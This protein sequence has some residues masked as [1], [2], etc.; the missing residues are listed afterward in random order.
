MKAPLIF[1]RLGITRGFIVGLISAFLG[2]FITRMIREAMGIDWTPA[3]ATNLQFEPT[4]TR[5][6]PYAIGS[7]TGT[8]G[9]LIGVGA[10]TDWL[11]WAVG[12]PGTD[13]HYHPKAGMPE[14]TRYFGMDTN[15]KVVGIQY[16]FTSL[17]VLG[18]GGFFA[19]GIRT[20]LAQAGPTV[21]EADTY[22]TFIG[23]H[24]MVMIVSVIIGI[25]AMAN[26]LVPL[27]IGAQDMAFPRLNGFAFWINVPAA[28]LLLIAPFV[29]GFDT[30]WTGYPPLSLK[31]PLGMQF[32]TMGV[33]VAGFSSIL[34]SLNLLTTIFLMRAPGMTLFRMPIFVWGI[35][36][37]SLLQLTA[38]QFIGLSFLMVT[39]ERLVG[40]PFFSPEGGGN[41]TLYQHLFWF[42]SHPAV[43]IFVLPGLGVISELLPVFSRKPLFGYVPIA[44]SSMA[45]AVMGYLV[46]AHHM[47][48]SAMDPSL[49]IPFMVTTLLVAVPTGVKFFSWL[50]TLWGG[51]IHF[52]TPMWF[53]LGAFMVFLLGGLTGP[54]SALVPTSVHLHDTHFVVAHFHM[55]IF[56]GYVFAFFGALYYWFPKVTGRM[57]NERLGLLHFGLMFPGFTIFTISLARI[58]ILGMRRRIYDYDPTW[59][60]DMNT[61]ERWNLL[62]T[63]GAY[64]VAIGGILMVG[65][66]LFNAAYGRKAVPNPWRS[67]G[68]EWQISSPP[69]ELN[70]SQ[71][72]E[73][74][75]HPYDYG[76]PGAVYAIVAPEDRAENPTDSGDSAS[77]TPMKPVVVPAPGD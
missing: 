50:G 10:M 26:Y 30:G 72:P 25:G 41:V 14:W 62:A 56:G 11:K 4:S 13:G 33:F 1:L 23:M 20:E 44:M 36:A 38:T 39:V 16:L 3:D 17:I 46:W 27:M 70:F 7:I 29:G 59:G 35:I 48:T 71:L 40:I 54:P 63:I 6:I 76:K 45:I 18:I 53:V 15:H 55:T 5:G 52:A 47:M 22:N 58:G 28:V 9:F 61:F 74:V 42:Y 75:G 37:T 31:A 2:V 34:G 64:M 19:L 66:F 32:F 73:I 68:L 8:L 67:L 60:F 57:Y 51:K 24:G 43:Y 77:P 65:N 69:P 49:R 12:I 21:M